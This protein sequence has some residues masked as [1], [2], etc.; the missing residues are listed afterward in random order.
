M[1]G[2]KLLFPRSYILQ[3]Y[4]KTHFL[5]IIKYAELAGIDVILVDDTKTVY[6]SDDHWTTGLKLSCEL[7]NKQIIF[8]YSDF[9][10]KHCPEK[11]SN[12]PYF[13]FQCNNINNHINMFPCG[14]VF[15]FPDEINILEEYFK[16]RDEFAYECCSTTV[17][18]KQLPRAGALL[19]RR[20]AQA[21]LLNNFNKKDIDITITE[22][23]KLFWKMHEKSLVAVC[24]PG[25]C[26]NSLDRGHFEL[27][28]LGVC[29]ISPVISIHLAW[30][31]KLI[32]GEHYISIKN[33]F[34]DLKEKVEWCLK[35]KNECNEIGNN[36]KK[37]FTECAIPEKYWEWIFKC[38]NDFYNNIK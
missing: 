16:I 37:L 28:G 21:F 33:D 11:Y 34:S 9:S 8:D 29:I 7:N 20:K 23:K 1:D 4:A 13:K 31:K 38:S 10:D 12:V 18:N 3:K 2:N 35:H 25:A 30:N 27:L 19:R 32:E 6:V 26:E 14:P 15:A 36:A 22:N 24:I 5:F 17:L